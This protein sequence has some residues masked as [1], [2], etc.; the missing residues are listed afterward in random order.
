RS[1]GLDHLERR[2]RVR[3][4]NRGRAAFAQRALE[5]CIELRPLPAFARHGLA[6]LAPHET[7]PVRLRL[8]SPFS[9]VIGPPPRAQRVFLPVDVLDDVGRATAEHPEPWA[10][11]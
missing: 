1:R 7:A 10:W 3:R 8:H 6:R 11:G 4:V 2:D 5:L 9:R